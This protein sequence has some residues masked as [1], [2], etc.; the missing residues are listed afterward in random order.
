M[1]LIVAQFKSHIHKN[2]KASRY[3]NRQT[4]DIDERKS[5]VSP[6]VSQGNFKMIF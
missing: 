2:E 4:G 1:K 6:Q 3:T 5:S